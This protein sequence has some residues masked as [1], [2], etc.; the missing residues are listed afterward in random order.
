VGDPTRL[1]QALLNYATNA[2]K[3]TEQGAVTCASFKQEETADSVTVRF[4]VQ[5]T[6]I[7]IT[8]ET[9]SRLFSAFEQADNSMTRKYGGTGLGLAITRR[10]ADLMGGEVGV[11][12]TQGVGSTFWFTV[13]LKKGGGQAQ[14]PPST[15]RIDAEAQLRKHRYASGKPR[16][17]R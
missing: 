3:F 10:L 1:Q 8:P 17:G 9:L 15:N 11:E 12:S 7:G 16:P 4:E 5:D 14:L 13:K 2:V 6:G